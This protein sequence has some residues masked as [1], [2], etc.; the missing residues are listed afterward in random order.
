MGGIVIRHLFW[1]RMAIH[2]DGRIIQGRHEKQKG[3]ANNGKAFF[4]TRQP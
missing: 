3:P 4:V 1:G 2:P